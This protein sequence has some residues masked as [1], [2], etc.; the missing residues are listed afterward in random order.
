MFFHA[1]KERFFNIKTYEQV[2]HITPLP[3]S[4]NFWVIKILFLVGGLLCIAAGIYG[5]V[6]PFI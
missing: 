4:F 2:K 3:I 5:I 6:I 1:T